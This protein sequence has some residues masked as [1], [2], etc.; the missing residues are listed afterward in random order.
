MKNN[1]KLAIKIK[2]YQ[3]IQEIIKKAFSSVDKYIEKDL[4]SPTK[5]S[6]FFK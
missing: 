2:E 1:K 6:I 5:I 4:K 3:Q